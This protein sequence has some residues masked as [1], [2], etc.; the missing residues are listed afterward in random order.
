V[1]ASVVYSPVKLTYAGLGLLT[2]G[3]GYVLTAGRADVADSIIYPAVTGDYVV[4]PRHLKGEKS[5]IFVGA[6]PD[7]SQDQK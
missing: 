4:T 6:P 5:V 1:L 7:T 2:G 3:L